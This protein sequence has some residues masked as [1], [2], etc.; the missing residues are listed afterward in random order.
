MARPLPDE[1]ALLEQLRSENVRIGQGLWELFSRRITEDTT[2]IALICRY[3]V[4]HGQPISVGDTHKI[5]VCSRDMENIVRTIAAGSKDDVV[6]TQFIDS[7]PLH[8]AIR[9]LFAHQL[10]NDVYAVNM[11]AGDYA[12][13]L[14]PRPVPP[15]DAARILR[16]TTSIV[17]FISIMKDAVAGLGSGDTSAQPRDLYRRLY[18]SISYG[19]ARLDMQ[20]SVVESNQALQKMTGYAKSEMTL[21]PLH[22]ICPYDWKT[23]AGQLADAQGPARGAGMEFERECVRKD[24]TIFPA[25]I[26]MRLI[27]DAGQELAGVWV[28]V[29]DIS[30]TRTEQRAILR[31]VWATQTVIEKIGD[32]ITLSNAAGHFEIFNSRM[33][34]L[35]GYTI[36]EVNRAG[37]LSALIY[38]DPVQ[39]SR[40][41]AGIN[42]VIGTQGVH[43]AE[44]VIR[45][46]DGSTR[47]VWVTT[48][49]IRYRNQDMFL[50]V[51]RDI[52]AQRKAEAELRRQ[53]EFTFRLIEGSSAPTFVIGKDHRVVIWNA[54]CE[55]ITGIKASDV[56]GTTD[57]WKG[58]YAHR[59]P[60]LA[61]IILDNDLQNISSFYPVTRRSDFTPNGWHAES[62]LVTHDGKERYLM[63]D[64]VPII[65]ESGEVSA[66][67][68]TLFDDTLGTVAE[69][70]RQMLNAELVKSNDKLKELALKDPHTGLYNFRYLQ[71]AIEP[72]FDR[73][74]RQG[75]PLSV[76]MLD[77]DFFKSINDVYG[78]QFGDYILKLVA[79]RLRRTVR[80]YDTVI[81]YGGEEFVIICPG[82]DRQNS[83][84]LAQ[85][86]IEEFNSRSL[87]NDEFSVRI[88]ISI[89][90]ASFPE[91]SA[92]R[93]MA[94]IDLADRILNRVK[95]AGG[96]KAF[97]FPD[98]FGGAEHLFYDTNDLK[99][100]KSKIERV[101]TRVNRIIVEELIA[102]ARNSCMR[103]SYSPVQL[104]EM[105]N[106]AVRI[107][108][109]MDLP[110]YAQEHIGEAAMIHDLGKLGLQADLLCKRE[111]LT[112]AEWVLMKQ[113]PQIAADILYSI[114]ALR[115]LIPA[116]LSH[117]ERWDGAGYPNGLKSEGIPREAAIIAV[118]DAFCALCADR[119]YRRAFPRD[120]AV[121]II[122]RASG[123][124]FCPDVV[125]S[126]MRVL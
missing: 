79:I 53:Q 10:G 93:G 35:T 12:D 123:T 66:V 49:L 50:S 57:H 38:L 84:H 61:D 5:L 111:P 121:S 32:G 99:T 58:F 72:E 124:Q 85:R 75:Q 27:E 34:E 43:E 21:M 87:G 74:K 59:R 96:D 62:W 122:E 15:E 91:D 71:N 94:L 80:T 110:V 108:K 125:E 3:S 106:L 102:F 22:Q 118:V 56:V 78:H 51:W 37:D 9:E 44:S 6:F 63:F 14:S 33:K 17:D 117:H 2:A 119:P 55:S 109:A 47:A 92:V 103:D 39:R 88:K 107:A 98:A 113:H 105:S 30:A 1:Q 31:E 81:R 83:R 82:S 18:D 90:I 67:I 76:M 60:C 70:E 54:A 116:V 19:L 29:R 24:G 16:H 13:P 73:A 36:D 77:I 100:I 65:D 4:S 112:D 7:V 97:T 68:E 25:L 23:V 42:E 86:I 126:F 120:E 11:V 20:G 64:A 95:E 28:I 89:G 114:P 26:K 46:K 52:T 45:A 8:P 104:E 48:S 40:A 101:N 41:L 69:R 115:Q